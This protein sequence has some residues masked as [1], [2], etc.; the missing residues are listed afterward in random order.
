VVNFIVDHLTKFGIGIL[1]IATV[2][3]M[4]IVLTC[5]LAKTISKST[6]EE[7]A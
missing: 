7:I 4:G 3:L 1:G 6:Y 2:H 5:L